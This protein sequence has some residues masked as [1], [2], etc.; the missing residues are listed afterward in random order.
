LGEQL[1]FIHPAT[2]LQSAS[3]QVLQH[4]SWQPRLQLPL[5]IVF[6][7]VVIQSREIVDIALDNRKP[8]R[9]PQQRGRSTQNTAHDCRFSFLSRGLLSG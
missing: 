8:V 5:P 7:L 6:H 2:V 1:D 9:C 4:C 3:A